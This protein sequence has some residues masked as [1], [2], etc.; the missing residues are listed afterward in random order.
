ME[1]KTYLPYRSAIQYKGFARAGWVGDYVDPFTFLS[2]FYTETNDS[3][4]GWWNPEYDRLIDRGNT[5]ADPMKRFELLAEAEYMMI[6][7]QPIIPLST[8]GTSWMK[9]PYIKGM[10][11]NAGTMHPWKF[12]YIERD[13]SKWDENV[14]N[15]M[16]VSDPQVEAQISAL[17]KSQEDFEKSKIA[18]SE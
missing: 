9:K 18:K 10:Y 5:T 15:I 3:S 2:Q 7:D 8:S 4:T 17:I 12:I 16:S 1:F 11:P 14:D 6:R 13:R